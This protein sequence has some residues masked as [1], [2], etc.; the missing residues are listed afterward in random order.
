MNFEVDNLISQNL[1]DYSQ[2]YSSRPNVHFKT[3]KGVQSIGN[4]WGLEGRRALTGATCVIFCKW[5]KGLKKYG[6]NEMI[7]NWTCDAVPL[8]RMTINTKNW[9]HL[10]YS[11]VR[12]F[13][14]P[15]C[16]QQQI[17]WF[18]VFVNDSLAVQIFKAIYKLTKVPVKG[19]G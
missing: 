9:S 15:V 18:N 8:K 12:D 17:P 4:L 1:L 3:W 10:C 14:C 11:Q 19:D 2:C 6:D 16:G 13:K 7:R 5:M